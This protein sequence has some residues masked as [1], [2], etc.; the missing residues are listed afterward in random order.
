MMLLEKFEGLSLNLEMKRIAVAI[1]SNEFLQM[2]QAAHK[3]TS[4]SGYVGAN[5]MH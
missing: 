5:R 3:L 2:N 1:D 4:A